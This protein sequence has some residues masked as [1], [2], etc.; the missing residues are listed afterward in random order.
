MEMTA[1]VLAEL[2]AETMEVVL[3][4]WAPI[5]VQQLL[6]IVLHY[7][8]MAVVSVALVEKAVESAAVMVEAEVP[9]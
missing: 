9:S 3:S 5:P 7:Q 2:S 4:C 6:K 8:T 1:M